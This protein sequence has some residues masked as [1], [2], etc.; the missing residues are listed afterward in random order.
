MHNFCIYPEEKTLVINQNGAHLKISRA[1]S[2]T[3]KVEK[4]EKLQ[5]VDGA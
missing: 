1:I 2:I 3:K 4:I 5:I